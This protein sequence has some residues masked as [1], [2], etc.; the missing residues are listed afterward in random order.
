MEGQ[1]KPLISSWLHPISVLYR[2]NGLDTFKFVRDIT[3]WS[4][5]L[6][7]GLDIRPLNGTAGETRGEIYSE[8]EATDIVS[9]ANPCNF[10]YFVPIT[11]VKL[12]GRGEF[13][14]I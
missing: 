1:E 3:G 8:G 12:T 5:R 10:E 4:E 14:G 9:R 13:S 11:R 6:P 2:W 7:A